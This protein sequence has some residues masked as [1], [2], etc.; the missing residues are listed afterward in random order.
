MKV[1]VD[2]E[3]GPSSIGNNL[4]LRAI[5]VVELTRMRITQ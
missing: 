4:R 5:S 1:A 3:S 2:D